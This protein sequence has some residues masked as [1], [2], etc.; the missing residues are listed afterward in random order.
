MSNIEFPFKKKQVREAL[1]LLTVGEPVTKALAVQRYRSFYGIDFENRIDHVRASLGIIKVSGFDIAAHVFMRDCPKGTVFV[2]HGLY[3]HVGIFDKPILYFLERGYS[4]VAYDLP[5]HGVSSGG[6]VAIK[7]FY[8]YQ[9]VLKAVIAFFKNEIPE[10]IYA[11]AQS[12]GGAVLLGAMLH[13]SSIEFAYP[14]KRTVLLAPLV[15]PVNWYRNK[16]I[17]SIV[18]PFIKYIPRNFTLNS[19]DESF[20]RFLREHDILQSRYLSADWVGALK[21]WVP[22]IE[23][24]E[25]CDCPALIIQGEKDETVDWRH[26]IPLLK[27]KLTNLE[28]L[29]IPEV[30]HQVANEIE[31]LR[32]LVFDSALE[33]IES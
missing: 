26:N 4:V 11:V 15:R 31:S 19:N 18:S 30:R 24:A 14:F 29:L 27:D 25:K 2:F 6:L 20:L 12:T 22:K 10:P 9:Q 17:H 16:V 32:K 1:P 3:D 5:G 23:S 33:F 28:V 21:Q 13:Q 8:R 7:T